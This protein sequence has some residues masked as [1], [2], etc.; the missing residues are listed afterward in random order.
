MNA[1]DAGRRRLYVYWRTTAERLPSARLAL[2]AWHRELG[3]GGAAGLEPTLWVRREPGRVTVM[4]VY[5]CAD[6]IDAALE[7]RLVEDGD[8][9]TRPHRDG[10]R[11]VEVFEPLA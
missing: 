2:L 1:P 6:G 9:V 3:T 5:A 7:R 11:H 10:P 8:A 4:E